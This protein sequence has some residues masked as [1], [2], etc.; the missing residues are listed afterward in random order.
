M[1]TSCSPSH[2]HHHHADHNRHILAT[3]CRGEFVDD[4]DSDDDSDGDDNDDG[5]YDVIAGW[6]DILLLKTVILINIIRIMCG[7]GV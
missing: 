6:R 4:C 7:A 5:A 2:H 3:V 1:L